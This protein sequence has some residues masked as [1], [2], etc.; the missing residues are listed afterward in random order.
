MRW[1]QIIR[2]A[3]SPDNIEEALWWVQRYVS[4]SLN[5]PDWEWDE[6]NTLNID[7]AMAM[8]SRYLGNGQSTG[9]PLSRYLLV[10]KNTAQRIVKSKVLPANQ[11]TFQSFTAASPK[12]ALEIG[13]E[14]NFSSTK[15]MVEIVVTTTPSPADVLFGFADAKAHQR[16]AGDL[17]TIWAQDWEHQQEVL[18]RVTGGLPL[19][20]VRVIKGKALDEDKT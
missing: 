12:E 4:G 16:K 2:E 7:T 15:G 13:R 14:I 8:V 6:P 1:N 5:D 9:K 19:D 20:K 11:Y 3:K 17:Y 18:V 10:D